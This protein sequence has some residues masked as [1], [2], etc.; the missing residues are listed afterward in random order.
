MTK[1]SSSILKD[2]V[3]PDEYVWINKSDEILYPIRIKLPMPE[4][5]ESITNY[6]MPAKEQVF[7]YESRPAKLEYL[8]NEVRR[9]A[10][11]EA[12]KNKQDT[13]AQQEQMFNEK[14]W[15][16]LE[17]NYEYYRREIEWIKKQWYYRLYGKWYFIN[18]KPVY[19]NGWNWYYLN[20]F[21]L[22]GAGLPEYRDRDRRWFHA[23]LYAYTT[24]ERPK[25]SPNGNLLK[26]PD[27]SLFMEDAGLRTMYGTNNL[28]G[29]RVGDTSKAESIGYNIVTLGSERKG[30]IQGDSKATSAET[31]GKLVFAFRKTPF[32]FRPTV[33]NPI[34]KSELDFDSKEFDKGIQS[35]INYA[36]TVMRSFYDGTKGHFFHVD[37]PGKLDARE[38]VFRR[39]EVLK[40]C[41]YQGT[42]LIGFMIYT[43]TVDD[44]TLQAGK[45]YFRLSRESHFEDRDEIGRT[46]SGLMNVFFSA[47][48]GAEGFVGRYGESIIGT[49]TPE[50]VK[51]LHPKVKNSRGEYMGAR[52]FY[53]SDREE[54]RRKKDIS[55]LTEVKR[56]HPMSFKEAF[57]P[58]AQNT[59]FNM[60][61][62]ES[63]MGE[64]QFDNKV[65]ANGNFE[66]ESGFG[67]KVVFHEKEEGARFSISERLN[68]HQANK[69]IKKG[70]VYYP[71]NGYKFVAS[72]DAFRLEKERL[73]GTRMSNGG[74]AVF[75][76]FDEEID[77]P[78]KDVSEYVT[79]NFVCIYKYRPS[80]PEEYVEDMLKMCI[81]YGAYMY[82]EN[83]I[84][85]IERN[86]RAWGY[87]GYLL[88]DTD[89]KT[90]KRK[91][92]AG[93][94][95]EGN[96]KKGLFNRG[97]EFI[98][99]HGSRCKFY[100][101]LEE[102]A[103]ISGLDEMTKYDLLTAALGCLKGQ[104][105][106]LR[107]RDRVNQ[108]QGV[109][110]GGVFPTYYY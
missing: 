81:Y 84:D 97:I 28:K 40:R 87:T 107:R 86:F 51:Y 21:P 70:N 108:F 56:L 72:G 29:R 88:S 54:K 104:E 7:R 1:V 13:V 96:A 45:E 26:N 57:T 20:Y 49:P 62:I 77:N 75:R 89:P 67:S 39:H 60:D 79:N 94:F 99:H 98:D 19:L 71:Q 83:N 9:E 18:G 34:P 10:R 31:F 109:D 53:E 82:P 52:E 58:P 35:K 69:K 95:S 14:I 32:F 24:T 42:N 11:V 65:V 55:G 63:R 12:R 4:D 50:Q 85:E 80:T 91:N 105:E 101:L 48:D 46:G 90:G 64:L 22:E 47:A 8:E 43:S 15:D 44:M 74:G 76:V 3:D 6:G 68:N 16:K 102:F 33:A 73:E 23:Q 36:T 25:K 100:S 27:G 61:V 59:F 66:W 110:I 5:I 30:G 38:S 103:Q 93:F 17:G 92:S 37:E 78:E 2:Y 106:I 41:V